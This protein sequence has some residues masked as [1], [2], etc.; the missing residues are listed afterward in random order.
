VDQLTKERMIRNEEIFREANQRIRE[1]AEE[2]G[3]DGAAP[4][5]CECSDQSCSE[6][7]LVSLEEYE[8]VR[9]DE[10]RFIHAPGHLSEI[11][12]VV[13]EADGYVVVEKAA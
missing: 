1:A 4:F 8:A 9:R 10:D 3:L 12:T 11:E 13:E 5:V 6:V 7:I 2:I